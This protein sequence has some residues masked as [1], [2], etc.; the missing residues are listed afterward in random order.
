MTLDELIHNIDTLDDKCVLCISSSIQQ[1]SAQTCVVLVDEF[2]SQR[3]PVIPCGFRQLNR[4][5]QLKKVLIGLKQLEG[6]LSHEALMARL[7]DYFTHE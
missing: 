4:L 5:W 2:D 7:L 6:T 3:Q 1:L